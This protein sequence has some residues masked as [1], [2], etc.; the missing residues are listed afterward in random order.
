MKFDARVIGIP[1]HLEGLKKALDKS[2]WQMEA[3]KFASA[4]QKLTTKL[5]PQKRA[6]SEFFRKR[7]PCAAHFRCERTN[8]LQPLFEYAC[9]VDGTTIEEVVQENAWTGSLHTVMLGTNDSLIVPFDFNVPYECEVEGRSH[10]Y[11]VASAAHVLKELDVLNEYVAV[12]QTL[13]AEDFGQ[14]VNWSK[15]AM[16]RFER[17][18]GVGRRFWAKMGLVALRGV[19]KRA[20]EAGLPVIID[21]QLGAIDPVMQP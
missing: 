10:I 8:L 19:V 11:V 1:T 13:G 18:E 15:Q 16:E 5:A 3:A 12:E 4:E 6:I 14:Y 17:Q 21:P 2:D 9:F 7:A 20:V